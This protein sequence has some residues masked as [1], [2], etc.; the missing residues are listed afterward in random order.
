MWLVMI[1]YP[2]WLLGRN[3]PTKL[4]QILHAIPESNYSGVHAQISELLRQAVKPLRDNGGFVVS[5]IPYTPPQ[6]CHE[7][8][9]KVPPIATN[10]FTTKICVVYTI[11]IAIYLSALGFEDITLMTREFDPKMAEYANTF[12]FNYTLEQEIKDMKFDVA[13]G[14]PPYEDPTNDGVKIFREFI[15]KSIEITKSDGL[16]ALITPNTWVSWN[17]EMIGG[18]LET[19]DISFIDTRSQYIK[20][21]YFPAVGSTF[22]WFVL[23]NR[24]DN[25]TSLMTYEGKVITDIRKMGFIPVENTAAKVRVNPTKATISIIQKYLNYQGK[26]QDGIFVTSGGVGTRTK[27]RPNQDQQFTVP[28]YCSTVEDHNL[29]F[30]EK[31]TNH[32]QSK[33]VLF[34]S[35]YVHNQAV[36]RARYCSHPVSTMN[37]IA[38]WVVNDDDQGK[39]IERFC[40]SKF[41]LFI[42][43]CLTSK[44]DIPI[45]LINN[46][47]VPQAM[48]YTWTDEELYNHFNLTDEEI[49]LIEETVK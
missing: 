1:Q 13:V 23:K 28:C 11:E 22:C 49:K 48:R 32:H 5:T 20:D 10:C 37:N 46:I 12:G 4:S 6:L 16:I 36:R 15:K 30:I 26:N 8:F 34:V 2:K 25:P 38:Y 19:R 44:R 39:S 14:N 41:L 3:M 45:P 33:K 35:S 27:H 7:I 40:N 42:I 18:V 9:E 47:K 31:E 29:R 43:F 21:T 24:T 17:D